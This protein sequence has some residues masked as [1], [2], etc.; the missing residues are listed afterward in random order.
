MENRI[1]YFPLWGRLGRTAN[2]MFELASAMG[3]AKRCGRELVVP[4]WY[5]PDVFKGSVRIEELQPTKE[6]S[7]LGFTYCGD[8][9]YDKLK[10]NEV[11]LDISGYLQSERYFERVAGD[12]RKFFT[13]KDDFNAL[14]RERWGFLLDKEL[15]ALHVRRGDYLTN[16]NYIELPLQ[17]YFSSL[18]MLGKTG[19]I[20][21]F[22]DDIPYCK[23][24]MGLMAKNIVFVEGQTD[25]EDLWLMSKCKNFIIANSTFSWWGAWL[26]EINGGRIIHPGAIFK[27]AMEK[28]HPVK[29]FFPKRWEE[30]K[31]WKR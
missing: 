23:K 11:Q 8:Y 19:T 17:Y 9:L 20:L 29:D 2:R 24:T 10:G 15:T 26:G 6:I 7:E 31:N 3:I 30:N 22:S 18:N 16:G 28:S 1:L 25:V 13:W 5:L 14:L 4:Q 21:I 27:G 12:I